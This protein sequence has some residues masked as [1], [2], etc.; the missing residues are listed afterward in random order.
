MATKKSGLRKRRKARKPRNAKVHFEGATL[1][2]IAKSRRI[3]G[4]GSTLSYKLANDGTLPTVVINGRRYVHL[5]KLREWL[6]S[7]G[8]TAA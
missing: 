3:T 6:D 5:P 4:L 1:A 2:S 8:G 7:L